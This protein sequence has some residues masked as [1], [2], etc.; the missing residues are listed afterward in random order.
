[1]LTTILLGILSS[2]VAEVITK[3]NKVL[4]GTVLQGDGAF[5]LAFGVAIVGALLKVGL[6]PG[7]HITDISALSAYFAQVWTV[8]QVFF[9]FVVSKL[10]LTVQANPQA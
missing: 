6:T 9:T 3:I 1:M 8:S 7:L 5:L 10:G 4:Q 2:V